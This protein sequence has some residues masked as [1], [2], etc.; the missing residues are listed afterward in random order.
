MSY[1]SQQPSRVAYSRSERYEPNPN[2]RVVKH[3]IKP[4]GESYQVVRPVAEAPSS[5]QIINKLVSQYGYKT[6]D[7]I[8]A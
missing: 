8:N 2:L 7:K 4:T 5:D 3:E 1:R 6:S